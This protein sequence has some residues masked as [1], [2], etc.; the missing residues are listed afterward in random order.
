L[1]TCEKH[2]RIYFQNINGLKFPRT[3]F[4]SDITEFV[5]SNNISVCGLAETKYN[6][7]DINRTFA[8]RQNARSALGQH[9]LIF[10]RS[11]MNKNTRQPVGG[12]LQLTTGA[13]EGRE[14]K[15]IHDERKMNRWVGQSFQLRQSRK[16]HVVTA[17]RPCKRKGQTVGNT[18]MTNH[19]RQVIQLHTQGI[20]QTDPRQ[21]FTDDLI[22]LLLRIKK[23]EDMIIIMLDAN[24]GMAEYQSGI[25]DLCIKLGLIDL[26]RSKKTLMREGEDI[27]ESDMHVST[28]VGGKQAIDFILGSKSLLPFVMAAGYLPFYEGLITDHR[29]AFVD[30]SPDLVSLVIPA[31]KTCKRSIGS[32]SSTKCRKRYTDYITKLFRE[33]KIQASIESLKRDFNPS[34][35]DKLD[36][37]VTRIVL[38]AEKRQ[39]R[40][41]ERPP[42]NEHQLVLGIKYWQ[43]IDKHLRRGINT[44]LQQLNI[45]KKIEKEWQFVI[46]GP[47]TDAFINIKMLKRRLQAAKRKNKLKQLDNEIQFF[48]EAYPSD[49]E[50]QMAYSQCKRTDQVKSLWQR[51]KQQLRPITKSGIRH[52]EKQ[53]P[54][55]ANRWI[56]IE[57]PAEIEK[58]ILTRNI[59]HFGQAHGTPFTIPPHPGSSLV[60]G[61]RRY[62]YHEHR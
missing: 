40:T 58:E 37:V 50:A 60:P 2:I 24:E 33:H 1:G 28:H 11:E 46:D 8:L 16:L 15:I 49:T 22:E 48:K 12:C 41:A 6:D 36:A 3:N 20:S 19:Q 45:K 14:T 9:R 26:I 35:L 31:N 10:A 18:T 7:L 61:N 44:D 5:R 32:H 27:S 51:I 59:E 4:W 25:K 54:E 34:A 53:D 47:S 30:L 42:K 62:W 17:Y 39:G 23:K 43:L 55:N 13:W 57:E 38:A 21:A 29:G 52:I 56:R